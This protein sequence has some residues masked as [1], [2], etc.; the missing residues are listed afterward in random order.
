VGVGFRTAAK[1]QRKSGRWVVWVVW[2]GRGGRRSG[3]GDV[4]FP[5]FWGWPQVPGRVPLLQDQE[6]LAVASTLPIA[7]R[8]TSRQHRT[9]HPTPN[10]VTANRP[11][12]HLHRW[13]GRAASNG[14]VPP[15]IDRT[16][17]RRPRKVVGWVHLSFALG[18]PV[19]GSETGR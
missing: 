3:L 1:R 17:G 15:T 13:G 8:H 18:V 5:S 19:A 11:L 16:V 14:A 6:S 9:Q 12:L 2:W 4:S 10:A 7:R